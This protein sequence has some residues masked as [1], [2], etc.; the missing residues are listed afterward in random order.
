MRIVI[1]GATGFIGS[2]LACKFLEEGGEVFALVRPGSSHLEALPVHDNLH[3]IWCDLEHTADCISQIGSADAF[4]HFAWGGVNRQEIDSPEVQAKKCS[5][6]PGLRAHG[7]G[8]VLPHIHGCGFQGRIW[9]D[10]WDH[11]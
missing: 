4:F 7:G 1:T 8:A 5:R 2:H 11:V 6:F 3:I 10:R 9:T